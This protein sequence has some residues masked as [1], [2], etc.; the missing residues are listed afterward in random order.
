MS[1]GPEFN[2]AAEETQPSSALYLKFIAGLDLLKNQST[3]LQRQANLEKQEREKS[4][5][6]INQPKGENEQLNAKIKQLAES[7]KL[8]LEENQALS[9]KLQGEKGH[10]VKL[11][12]TVHHLHATITKAL[13]THEIMASAYPDTVIQPALNQ[14]VDISPQCRDECLVKFNHDSRTSA[15]QRSETL[16]SPHP[17]DELGQDFQVSDTS[18]SQTTPNSSQ[19]LK[20]KRT[21]DNL[22]NSP[23]SINAED[24]SSPPFKRQSVR[25]SERT[26]KITEKARVWR[27]S[28]QRSSG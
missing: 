15:D 28:E 11:I 7:K 12:D 6:L 1:N 20:R 16:G 18:G 9:Q 4:H 24:L 14:V 2:N 10:G 27:L 22:E 19:A 5:K 26:S 25:K 3:S 13:Q 21:N 23:D 8:L 17:L